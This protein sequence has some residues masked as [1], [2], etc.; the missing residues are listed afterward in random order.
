MLLN[1]PE[2]MWYHILRRYFMNIIKSFNNSLPTVSFAASELERYLDMLP[3][4]AGEMSFTLSVDE[5]CNFDK[6]E[7]F[8]ETDRLGGMI[9]ASNPRSVLLGVYDYLTGLGFRFLMPGKDGVRVP[10]YICDDDFCRDKHYSEDFR[11]RGICI[12][13]ADSLENVLDMIDWLPKLGFNGF[14]I[15][16]KEPYIFLERWYDHIFNPELPAENP[17]SEFYETCFSAI[18]DAV[19]LRGLSLHAVG[20]GFVAEVLGNPSGGWMK[21]SVPLNERTRGMTALIGGRREFVN[22]IPADTNLCY[23]DPEAVDALC[24]TVTGYVRTHPDVD[25]L[26]FWLADEPNNICEC[27]LCRSVTPSDQYVRILN[28]IDERLTAEGLN[29]RIVFLLYQELLYPP[30]TETI[31]NPERFVMMFA[32]ISRTYESSYPDHPV[33]TPLP[34][35]IRNRMTLPA[36]IDMNLSFLSAWQDHFKGESFV[37]DYPLGKTHYGDFGYMK[38]SRT[39]FDDI[40]HLHSLGLD[41]YM[42]CQELRAFCPTAFPDYVMGRALSDRDITFEELVREYFSASYE[43]GWEFAVSYLS[44]LSA[45]SPMDHFAGYGPRADSEAAV[46]YERLASIFEE[47]IPELDQRREAAAEECRI[48]WSVLCFHARYGLLLTKALAAL[49]RGNGSE[50]L[51]LYERFVSYIRRHEEHFQPFLDVY[52]MIEVTGKYTFPS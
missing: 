16:F 38:I 47:N 6:D 10:G 32:P 5:P 50:A 39:I 42:S 26:H 28:R 17:S 45:S 7:Y 36:D 25:Y 48:S 51:S 18:R 40:R 31:K 14:F 34:P 52:R 19:S 41:G 49:A 29:C 24:D 27:E 2:I 8:I 20:H 9:R 33:R 11:F 23:S 1:I 22:D 3:G 15:Q 13:G 21:A 43:D 12:E 37:Y 30:L 35:Y 4:P 44:S 46:S